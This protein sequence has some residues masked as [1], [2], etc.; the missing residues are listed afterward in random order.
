MRYADRVVAVGIET[1]L[2]GIVPHYGE[3]VRIPLHYRDH[4]VEYVRDA[5]MKQ[6][7]LTRPPA[8]TTSPISTKQASTSTE[9]TRATTSTINAS[10][11]PVGTTTPAPRKSDIHCVI[12]GDML[13][14]R[15]R[16]TYDRV[17]FSFFLQNYAVCSSQ[18][19]VVTVPVQQIFT[20]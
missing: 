15:D 9:T 1:D 19:H 18:I 12:A 7:P 17:S 11:K 13:N 4:Y 2:G 16:P 5:I 14:I 3:A 20:D 6:P 8:P 10:T